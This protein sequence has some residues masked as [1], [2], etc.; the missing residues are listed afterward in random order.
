MMYPGK[1][2]WRLI[3]VVPVMVWLLAGCGL[4]PKTIDLVA[5][6]PTLESSES[7]ATIAATVKDKQGK[8]VSGQK[9]TFQV[10][11]G[12]GLVVAVA[13]TTD[14]EGKA[15]ATYTP[16]QQGGEAT[17]EAQ[18]GKIK[19]TVTLAVGPGPDKVGPFACKAVKEG[20][21]VHGAV[22]CFGI[23]IFFITKAA[24]GKEPGERA[25]IV[26]NRLNGLV[27][28][29]GQEKRLMPDM[30]AVGKINGEVVL[31]H[32]PMEGQG[33]LEEIVTIDDNIAEEASVSTQDLAKWWLAILKDSVALADKMSPEATGNSNYGTIIK[34]V[35]E[36]AEHAGGDWLPAV[37][38]AV[39][40]LSDEEQ[41]AL[42]EACESVPAS[43]ITGTGSTGERHERHHEHED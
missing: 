11:Q 37:W 38:E 40:S 14:N 30:L 24:G 21:R 17:V 5:D 1:H 41:D 16:G 7:N 4:Q 6:P 3:S 23:P 9:V 13:G 25:C 10:S 22:T 42:H 28:E 19:Q 32:E 12:A 15:T 34:K 20:N 39:R 35:Y 36:A 29:H 43:P 31:G 26:A 33:E 27:A 8:A 18:V 2:S